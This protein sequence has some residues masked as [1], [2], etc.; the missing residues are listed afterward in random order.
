MRDAAGYLP[1]LTLPEN[2]GWGLG[3]GEQ[4]CGGGTTV[5]TIPFFKGLL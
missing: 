1:Q 2:E 4:P 3:P 5:S